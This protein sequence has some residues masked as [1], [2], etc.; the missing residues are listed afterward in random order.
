MVANLESPQAVKDNKLKHDRTRTSLW[1]C[2]G[3]EG[4][5]GEMLAGVRLGEQKKKWYKGFL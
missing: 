1:L 5:L 2:A 4:S 3:P